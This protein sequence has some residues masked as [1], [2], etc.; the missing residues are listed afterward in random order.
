MNTRRRTSVDREGLRAT[1]A[2]AAC[3]ASGDLG[4][5]PN[6]LIRQ[7]RSL[8]SS[9]ALYLP[10]AC[11]LSRDLDSARFHN[12]AEAAYPIIAG[13]PRYGERLA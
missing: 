5:L 9:A 3:R 11:G 1:A 2:A 10:A 7:A 4:C 8:P 13:P 6:R 12:K